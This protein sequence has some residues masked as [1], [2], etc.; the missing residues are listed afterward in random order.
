MMDEPHKIFLGVID[1]RP[2]EVAAISAPPDAD[3]AT[4]AAAIKAANEAQL[5]ESKRLRELFPIEDKK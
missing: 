2:G 3:A 4:I 5:A 1:I